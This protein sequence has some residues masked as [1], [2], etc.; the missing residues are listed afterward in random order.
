MRVFREEKI[1]RKRRTLKFSRR[2]KIFVYLDLARAAHR[3]INIPGLTVIGSR[4]F[5]IPRSRTSSASDRFNFQEIPPSAS[6]RFPPRPRWQPHPRMHLSNYADVT[7]RPFFSCSTRR[8]STSAPAQTPNVVRPP[9]PKRPLVNLFHPHELLL[10]FPDP[11]GNEFLLQS[12]K[13]C[14]MIA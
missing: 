4:F 8:C 13:D 6:L 2:R 12:E 7:G 11:K 5:S 14:W 3:E 10:Q 9:P 1:Y